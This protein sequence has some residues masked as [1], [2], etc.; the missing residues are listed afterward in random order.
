MKPPSKTE[1]I[2]KV[3]R[4]IHEPLLMADTKVEQ[5]LKDCQYDCDEEHCACYFKEEKALEQISA[6]ISQSRQSLISEII[7]IIWSEVE[8]CEPDCSDVR[9]ATHQGQW[10]MAVRLESILEGHRKEGL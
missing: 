2:E 8:P 1:E 7:E 5:I 3:G 4:Y 10:D 6:L 9:H